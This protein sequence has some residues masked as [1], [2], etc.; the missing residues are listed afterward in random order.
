MA[1]YLYN[2]VVL[3]ALPEWDKTT[4]PYAVINCA[5]G[6]Y[7]LW[8]PLSPVF[9]CVNVDTSE[10]LWDNALL[11]SLGDSYNTVWNGWD[12]LKY[13]YNADSGAWEYT[14]DRVSP[15][16][17]KIHNTSIGDDRLVWANYDVPVFDGSA[18]GNPLT[19]DI[20]LAASDPVPVAT[21]DRPD[22][23]RKAIAYGLLLMRGTQ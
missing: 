13:V 2:G 19:G 12:G 18:S 23:L 8:I 5:D 9:Y 10:T 1:N 3:P 7:T 21:L 14:G 11:L 17:A 16:N 6:V 22:R 4:Y 15:F 20:Y